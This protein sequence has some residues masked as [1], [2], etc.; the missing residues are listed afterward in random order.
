MIVVFEKAELSPSITAS[1]SKMKMVLITYNPI[2][3][4][5]YNSLLDVEKKWKIFLSFAGGAGPNSL[6]L[7]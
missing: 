3:N 5:K 6:V 7:I 1:G 2:M 4:G